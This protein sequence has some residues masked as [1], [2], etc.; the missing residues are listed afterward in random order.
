M[1][2][3]LGCG[4]FPKPGFTNIDR[5][6]MP[7]VDVVHD[8]RVF[9]YP[10]ADASVDHIEADHVLEHL[11]N[12]AGVMAECHRLLKSGGTLHLRVP[13]FSRGFSHPEHTTG[14]DVTY[15]YYY[16]P[17]FQGGY[18]GIPFQCDR[19]RLRWFAW[20]HLKRTVVSGWLVT[21][22]QV[23]GYVVDFI[24]NLS[25]FLCSRVWC[26]WVGGFEEVEFHFRKP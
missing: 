9:P 14:F 2:L 26:F 19:T 11:G 8:L 20:P 22:G 1:K 24:A 12:A 5:S 3:N 4:R 17:S 16:D 15:P 21:L 25:P 18:T 10:F 23:V 7:G 6:E 13:H